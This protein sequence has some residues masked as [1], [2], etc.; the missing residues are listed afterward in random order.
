M[1]AADEVILRLS[2]NDENLVL[3]MIKIAKYNE[4]NVEYRSTI[5]QKAQHFVSTVLGFCYYSCIYV[6]LNVAIC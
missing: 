3:S 2:E 6:V 5:Q 1:F 4:Q